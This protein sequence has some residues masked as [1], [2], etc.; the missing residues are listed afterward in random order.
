MEEERRAAI[1]TI[2]Q[3]VR[4]SPAMLVTL[5][6]LTIHNEDVRELARAEKRFS[7]TQSSADSPDHPE[8]GTPASFAVPPGLIARSGN[9]AGADHL[10]LAREGDAGILEPGSPAG[11]IL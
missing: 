4:A 6:R 1:E 10:L 7:S 2:G 3:Q 5:R 8:Q 11:R 9:G